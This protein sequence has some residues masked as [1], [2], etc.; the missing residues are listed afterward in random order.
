MAVIP[1]MTKAR[2]EL[3]LRYPF[4]GKLALG[5]ELIES[6]QFD[7]MAVDGQHIYYNKT[8]VK[9]LTHKEIVGV[10]AHEVLHVVF[11]HHLRRGDRD[12]HWWN[13]AGDYVINAVLLE[14]GFILPDDG[15]FNDDYAGMSTEKVYDLVY[16]DNKDDSQEIIAKGMVGEVI[17]A[18]SKDG[19]SLSETEIKELER[20]I[21]ISVMQAEQ[22]AKSIG[23]GGDARK[24]MMDTIKKQSVNWRDVLSNLMLDNLVPC[25]YNFNNP[26]RRFIY[27]GMYLP[28]VEKEPS[29]EIA[30]AIDISGSIAKD[31]MAM[32]IDAVNNI[33][34]VANPNKV[35]II[36]CD[37]CVRQVD[38]FEKGEEVKLNYIL[39]GGTD[40]DPVFKYIDKT[41]QNEVAYLVYLTDGYGYCN[42]DEP[43]YPTIWATIGTRHYFKFGEVVEVS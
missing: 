23:K 21:N 19:G 6:D 11:K 38:V 36:Y 25:D 16:Q 5:L 41:L 14:D 12:K 43:Y 15:L 42:M 30:I 32:F 10:I 1:E 31:E 40:F 22:S 26:N 9:S 33:V 39:G 29:Q 34:S 37:D 8:W 24:A 4:F 7:T 3:V 2:T 13:V 35:H 27:Q 28:S 18:V 17:D 20:E